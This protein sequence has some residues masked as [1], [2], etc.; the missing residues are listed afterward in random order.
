MCPFGTNV[1]ARAGDLVPNGHNCSVIDTELVRRLLAA[2]FP[3]WAELPVEPIVPGGWDN[4]T[5][6]LGDR[7]TVR[8]PSAEGYLLQVE[9]EQRWL[10][11]LAK[12][13]TLPIPTPIALGKPGEGFPWPWSIYCW[14]DGEVSTDA[15]IRDIRSFATDLAGFL[16]A[17]R[18]ADATDGPLPGP[19]NFFRGGSPAFYDAEARQAIV[20][21]G[22]SIDGAAATDVW[23]AA[24]STEWTLPPVWFHGDISGGNL[25]VRDGE[26]SAVIDF[27]TSGIGDP[28]CDLVIAFS[29]LASQREH[30][31]KLIDLDTATWAR[32]RGWAIWKALI[33]AAGSVGTHDPEGEAIKARRVIDE[34][35]ADH[36]S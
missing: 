29:T 6:R 21:L 35:I 3:Q 1:P 30:F 33:V 23:D 18:G 36:Q 28:A 20:D 16:V 22:S 9:K 4:R 25:L 27:G 26:L 14:I 31:R 5:F 11:L 7:M 19:H 17:L 2:Q 24:L 12:Q 32:A 10:P 34:V 13:L 8:L 15:K